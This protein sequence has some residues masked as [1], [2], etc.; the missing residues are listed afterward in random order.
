MPARQTDRQ[1]TTAKSIWWSITA[2]NDEIEL[3]EAPD[4]YPSFIKRIYGG[5]ERCPTTGTEHFQGAIQCHEQVRL[6]AIKQHFKTA[7]LEPARQQEALVKYAMKPD[8]ATGEKLERVNQARHY[9]ADELLIEIAYTLYSHRNEERYMGEEGART[10][11]NDAIQVML[12]NDRKLAGQLMNPSLR[13][14]YIIT[15]PVW[16][17]HAGERVARE[18]E[19]L[20]NEPYTD[21]VP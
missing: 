16:L 8:T 5:R 17:R 6:S 21:A 4:K 1:T 12:Y 9:T 19:A 13:N 20:T 10:Y 2:F 3:C 14:F 18:H 15:A 7:H 11:F